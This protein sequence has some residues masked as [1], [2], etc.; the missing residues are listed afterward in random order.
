MGWA[1]PTFVP[2]FLPRFVQPS[3]Q[4]VAM[5]KEEDMEPRMLNQ[6]GGFFPATENVQALDGLAASTLH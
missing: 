2:W 1:E 4:A 5:D 3:R 6:S